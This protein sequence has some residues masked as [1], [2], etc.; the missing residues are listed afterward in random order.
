MSLSFAAK[1][2]IQIIDI[3][4]VKFILGRRLPLAFTLGTGQVMDTSVPLPFLF[5]NFFI[6]F[7]D[8]RSDFTKK[9]KHLKNFFFFS[10]M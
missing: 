5:F 10:F 2:I 3:E 8:L 6:F 1:L 7:T 4:M 9:K